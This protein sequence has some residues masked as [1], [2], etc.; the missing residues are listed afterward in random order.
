MSSSFLELRSFS[1]EAADAE[2][3]P[4]PDPSR[5]GL[6][7]AELLGLERLEGQ[8][9]R[10][11]AACVLAPRQRASSPLLKRFMENRRVLIRAEREIL[12]HNRPEVQ[13]IDADWMADNFHI[14]HEVLREVRQD[15]PRGY[16]Q[17]LPKLGMRPLSGYPRVYALALSLVSHTDSE[18]D[19]TRISRFV[20]AFQQVA[21]LTIGE[22]WA[23]PTMLRL[24]LVE[25][26]RRL[27]D[28]MLWGWDERRR[29]ELWCEQATSPVRGKEGDSQPKALTPRLPRPGELTGP[30]VVRVLQVLRDKGPSAAAA[31]SHIEAGLLA[32]GQEP[33]EIISRE[34]H[35]QASN[36][37]TVGNCVLSL[38]LLSAVDWNAFFERTSVVQK[39]LR[40]DPTGAYPLQDFATSDRYR[41]AVERIARGSNADE[42]DVARK[43]IELASAGAEQGAARGHVGFYLVDRGEAALRRIFGCQQDLRERL[44][45]WALAHPRTTYFG[46]ILVLGILLLGVLASSVFATAGSAGWIWLVLICLAA[47]LPMSELAVGLVNHLLTVLLPPRVLPKFDFKEDIPEEFASIVVIPSML[48]RS[49]SAEVLLERLEI[50]F[51]ANPSSS[52]R[53]ALLTDFADAPKE[54]MPEDEALLSDALA[55]V[56]A[57]NDR[58]CGDGP[59]LFF[60]FHRRRLW[61]PSQGC[62]MG[63]ERKRGKL[64]EFN[65]L[66]RGDRKT[67]YSVWSSDPANLPRTRFVI[68][69]DTDTQMPRDTVGRLVGTLAHPLNQPRFDPAQ[70]RVV[71]GYGVLQ[72][73]VSFHL[74]AATHSHFASLLA[75]SGGIDPYSTA[76]SDAYMDLFG[77]GSFTGKGIYDVD[78]FEAATGETFPENRILSHDLIEGNYARCGLLSD[79]EL[80]DDFPARYHAYARREHR[81]VRGD[82][83]LLPWLGTEVPAPE[84]EVPNALPALERWKLFDNLRRSLV[85]PSLVLFLVLGWIAFPG[86]PW[87]WSA[88]ALA[89]LALPLLKWLISAILRCVRTASWAGIRL[90]RESIPAMGGQ[91]LLAIVFLADQAWLMCDAVGRTLIRLLVTHRKMLEWET[92][93]STEQRLGTG[94]ANF[95][96][97]MWSSPALAVVIATLIAI[98]RPE[99]LWAAGPIL[100]AWLVAPLV[101]FWVSRPKPLSLLQLVDDDRRELRRI[102]RR[103]WRFFETF[104]GDRDHWLP[105]DNF[106]EIPDGRVA[107]RTSPTNQG[108]LLLSTL[109]AHDLGY[110]GFGSLAQR[111]EKTFDSLEHM[112]KHWGHFFNWYD[113]LTLKPL[114]PTYLSTVDSGNFLG[115]LV[116]LK[117]G[118]N[119]KTREPVLGPRVVDGLADT[120]D[121]IA[122]PWRHGS[123]GVDR[124]FQ[125]PP[126]ALTGWTRWLEEMEKEASAL[127]EGILARGSAQDDD[128]AEAEVWARALLAQVQERRSELAALAPWLSDPGERTDPPQEPSLEDLVRESRGASGERHFVAAEL[129]DRL[130]ALA[131]RA[132]ALGTAID[133]RPLYKQERHLYAIGMNLS[134]GQ[135]DGPCYDLLASE[136]CLT[137]YLTIARGDAPRRHWFQ[138][139]RP[140]IRAAGHL[141]LISWGGTMFEYLMPRLLL[142]SLPNTLLAEACQTAVARQIEYGKRMGIPWGI[143]ES[144][145]AAQFGEGD[146]RYQSFGVPG[147]G[148]KRGLEKDRVVAPYATAIAAMVAPREALE[149][150]RRLRNEGALG[151]YGF[152]EAIDYTPERL[153][154]KERSVVVRSYMAHHQGMSLV[155]LT[156]VLLDEVMSRRF[157]GEPMVKAAELLLQERVPADSPVVET[158]LADSAQA[159]QARSPGASLLSRRLTTPLTLC[160]RTQLLSNSRYHVMLTNSGSGY[161][162]SQ[163][164]DVT[165]WREDGSCECWGQFFYVRDLQTGQFWSAGYQPVCRPADA[166]EVVFSADKALFRRRDGDLETVLEVAVSPEQ[167]A[168]VRRITLTNHGIHPRELELTSYAE[169]VLLDHRADLAH[170]A[171]GKL[172]LETERVAGS[173]SLLCRRRPRSSHEQPKWAVHVMAVDRAALGCQLVGDLQ[174]ETDRARFLGRGRTPADPAAVGLGVALSGTTGPVLDPVFSLRRG[175]RIGPGGSAVIGFTLALAESR[176]AALALADKYHEA[177][178]VARAFELAWAHTQVEHEHRNWSP[179]DAHLYQ[180]LGSHLLFAG[181]ALRASAAIIAANHLAQPALWRFGVSG[182]RPIILARIAEEAEL[183]LVRQLLVAHGFL[184]LKGLEADLVLLDEERDSDSEGVSEQ[185]AQVVREAG[186]DELANRPG[187]VFVLRKEELSEDEA[188]LLEATA[189][190][191]LDGARGSLSTQLDRIEWVR[192][193]PELLVP[194]QPPGHWNDEPVRLPEGLQFD[195]GLG[196]F[197]ADGRE[198]CL[199]IRSLDPYSGLSSQNGQAGRASNPRPILPPA[200]WINVVA[201]PTVGFL[202][203][204]SGAGYTWAGNSQTNRLT[205]WSNDPVIDPPSEV[206][207]LRDEQT[208]ETWCPT[209]LPIPS[210]APVLVR[211]GQGYT[212]FTS[213]SHGLEHE[214]T[215]SVPVNDP[216]KLV[217]L[218]IR[219]ATA[220]PRRLSATFYVEWVLGTTRDASAMHVVTELD[221]DTGALLAR[222]AFRADFGARVA[223][224]DLNRRPRTITAD[225]NEFLGRHGSLAAPAVMGR[226]ELSGRRGGRNRPM[227]GRP[228]EIRAR[229]R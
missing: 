112:E 170:P 56:R 195:N 19:E 39:I 139:G 200:P 2:S 207:Y 73:R 60:L 143:S 32:Q 82:W 81:W 38:R 141:G 20:Q 25:N 204:E 151:P 169:V 17:V 140:Y 133:F 1:G 62:W 5:Q 189:R 58:Y 222:N 144:A 23:L 219:N 45:D 206:V 179:E 198:Y 24:V 12:G 22:L 103:T 64:S 44:L 157:H 109:A 33:D 3:S 90:W 171:F 119:E 173:D 211:H 138:L 107:H 70:R 116:A 218:R 84:G 202:I 185:L 122:G 180:R 192:S 150:F 156:N 57:L 79:T 88:T 61:N 168:E 227:C 63:W 190:V 21:P 93:A 31:M 43:A 111:L 194:E 205:G 217:V 209:P 10:L 178:A 216:I 83:Q 35:R 159:R 14:V 80:F 199:L 214:L 223:F 34:H 77:L 225:R 197:S 153:G 131:G 147:L 121:L 215:L 145:Y 15:L 86:S 91:V 95:V 117:Q 134:Q 67:S 229:S 164:L 129:R 92:A 228:D 66:I 158:A 161:S 99:A 166:Y 26:L 220:Q 196:G 74:T 132:E 154:P 105:P 184:R 106:Q 176:D 68:T 130:I 174:F 120:F 226:S 163:G 172:F 186:F 127:L 16:D 126:N 101:A 115:C 54:V 28:Q 182:D 125:N 9:R 123:S 160:T 177:S 149:N 27:A 37:L 47:L 18:L 183:S 162:V 135:L 78:A 188:I 52:L 137:S 11:A 42:V 142:R 187:G 7:R 193:Q 59:E 53:F 13:G 94:L 51:L 48:V 96:S 97:S 8:A 110:I 224:V 191:V 152:Y 41:K 113:T 208:G 114:P 221:P 40:D 100:A 72:P 118:L 69:L 4:L 148:L 136:S 108:L 213:N 50:H 46:S 175:F 55:R 165:R 29:A 167:T 201:N 65:R 210:E 146:Y 128:G 203:S 71:E 212:V 49:R 76:A 104:V 89:V 98:G 124:L 85:P 155:A 30:F 36:Q 181:P 102:T 6:I 75:A 87:L